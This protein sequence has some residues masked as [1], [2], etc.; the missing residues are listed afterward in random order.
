MSLSLTSCVLTQRHRV[1]EDFQ[2]VEFPV[3]LLPEDLVQG[4]V[5]HF[6]MTRD[7][8]AEKGVLTELQT[9][10]EA[11]AVEEAPEPPVPSEERKE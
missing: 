9:L 10:Q 7:R 1:T 3:G 2:V 8:V 4:T 11:L 6:E 5:V